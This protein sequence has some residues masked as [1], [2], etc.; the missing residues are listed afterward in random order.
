LL[1]IVSQKL[2]TKIENS[3]VELDFKK[4]ESWLMRKMIKAWL[5]CL[6]AIN[7]LQKSIAKNLKARR[8]KT[9]SQLLS[10]KT[11]QTNRTI[12]THGIW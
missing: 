11:A 9:K 3:I 4:L 7:L 8:E 6:E 12:T 2:Q 1:A 5:L 10:Q